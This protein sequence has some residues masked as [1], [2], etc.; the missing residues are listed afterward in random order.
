MQM[1][2]EKASKIDLIRNFANLTVE[3]IAKVGYPSF[4]TLTKVHGLEKVEKVTSMLF[5]DLSATFN[6]DLSPEQVE[7]ITAEISSS[8]MRNV[9]LEDIYLVCRKIKKSKNYGKLNVNKVLIS[10]EE[11]FENKC[12]AVLQHNI[13]QDKKGTKTIPPERNSTKGLEQMNKNRQAHIKY[14]KQQA[15]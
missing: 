6:D 2:L 13:N 11:H 12:E 10:L 8:L 1:A 3:K 15:K 4:G 9:S 7:E 14:I 5:L